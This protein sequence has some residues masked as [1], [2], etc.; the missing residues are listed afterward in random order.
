MTYADVMP[1]PPPAPEGIAGGRQ[2]PV[3]EEMRKTP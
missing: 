3:L 1:F 2:A